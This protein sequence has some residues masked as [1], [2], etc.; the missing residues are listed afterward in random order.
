MRD[1][2][3]LVRS[4]QVAQDVFDEAV[5]EWLGINRTDHRVLDVLQREGR[6]AAGRLARLAGL[7][8]AAMTTSIDRLE[9]IGYARRAID[10]ADR[11]RVMVDITEL[12]ERRAWEIYEP[13]KLEAEKQWLGMSAAD[14]QTLKRFWTDMIGFNERHLERVRSTPKPK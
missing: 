10:P 1:L 8:P 5:S 3:D 14:L 2:A 13:L 11:R 9:R 7:S 12:A 4:Q 6:I